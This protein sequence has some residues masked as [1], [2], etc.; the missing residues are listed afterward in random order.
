RDGLARDQRPLGAEPGDGP[1][2]WARQLL[3]RQTAAG[4]GGEPVGVEHV[5]DAEGNAEQGTA[6]ERIRMRGKGLV[7]LP[8]QAREAARLQQKSPDRRLPF[9]EALLQLL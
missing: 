1:R 6:G 2:L 5:L 9:R 3:R 7:R 4:A 8:V